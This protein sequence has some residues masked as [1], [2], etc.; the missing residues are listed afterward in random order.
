MKERGGMTYLKRMRTGYIILFVVLISI[1]LTQYFARNVERRYTSSIGTSIV[2]IEKQHL[3]AEK[4]SRVLIETLHDN[5]KKADEHLE[6]LGVEVSLLR[7]YQQ[8]IQKIFSQVIDKNTVRTSSKILRRYENEQQLFVNLLQSYIL[9]DQEFTVEDIDLIENRLNSLHLVQRELVDHLLNRDEAIADRFSAL[10]IILFLIYVVFLFITFKLFWKPIQTIYD[11]SKQKQNKLVSFSKEKKLIDTAIRAN[12]QLIY[13]YDELENHIEW[14]GDSEQL[15]GYRT[16]ELEAFGPTWEELLE[17][18]NKQ[19]YLSQLK[20]LRDS[21]TPYHLSY[22]LSRKDGAVVSIN[23]I[24]SFIHDQKGNTIGRIGT[25]IDVSEVEYAMSLI[26]TTKEKLDHIFKH[27]SDGFV[28]LKV[29]KNEEGDIEDYLFLECNNSFLQLLGVDD[30]IGS[31][32]SMFFPALLNDN[33]QWKNLFT[34]AM[35]GVEKQNEELYSSALKKWLRVS[36]FS[37]Q[38]EYV[39]VV[40]ADISEL[41]ENIEKLKESEKR[42]R[43]AFTTSAIGMGLV[44]KDGFIL[45]SNPSLARMLGYDVKYFENRNIRDFAHQ[46]DFALREEY[47]RR[48]LQGEMT[49]YEV[50]Q[51]MIK[52]DGDIVW[53]D[54]TA[55]LIRDED[56][57]PVYFVT[58]IQDI[59]D[60]KMREGRLAELNTIKNR[61]INVISHQLRTPL[62][63]ISWNIESLISGDLGKM[64]ADQLEFLR[65]TGKASAD[66]IDRLTDMVT[67]LD[68]EEDKDRM[69]EEELNISSVAAS[70]VSELDD[71][72]KVKEISIDSTGIDQKIPM[73]I[74]DR[75]KMISSMKHLL[76][77][78]IIFSPNGKSVKVTLKK[79]KQSIYYEVKDEGVGI[80]EVEQDRVYEKFYRASNAFSMAPDHSGLGLFITKSFIDAHKGQVGFAS[81]EGKGSTFWFTIPIQSPNKKL[82]S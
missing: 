18:Q 31:S 45:E 59:T 55:S 61:F 6:Q 21:E 43:G 47:I 7:E 10:N 81:K 5:P 63:S 37:P 79:K 73:I 62:T 11:Q 54:I 64:K 32:A 3:L 66:V 80:P 25:L 2:I 48:T 51:R 17:D 30:I 68:I 60:R 14:F 9:H 71:M 58:L 20:R 34:L 28:L 69:V 27:M 75:K 70:V 22:K 56:G 1:L 8:D 26:K 76:K 67:A 78:A 42:F 50:E 82:D 41:K 19:E 23:D 74:A 12:N 35:K 49:H 72:A 36:V 77:N 13:Y 46:E 53:T 33:V 16:R 29:V 65:A 52:K 15:T 38:E 40:L 39:A 44:D 4:S 24:G 57:H